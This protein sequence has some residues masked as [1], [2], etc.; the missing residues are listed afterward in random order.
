MIPSST[1]P[2]RTTR[3][4]AD[5]S[6]LAAEAFFSS[7]ARAE[8]VSA[9]NGTPAG[10]G[11]ARRSSARSCAS[12][13]R[14]SS[15]TRARTAWRWSASARAASTSPAPAPRRCSEI[16]RRRADPVRRR[17]HH[18]LPRRPRPRHADAA[19]AG[20]RHRVSP[21]TAGASCWSTTCSSP[22][23]RS[24][25]RMDALIDFGRPAV[26]PARGAGRPRASRAADPRRLR[27]QE[28]ADRARTSR[29]SVRLAEARRRRRGR[30]SRPA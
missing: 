9:T 4:R 30:A 8:R 25:P 14:S 23:A 16:E 1:G 15:A 29:S 26:D 19:R 21:S 17:R 2:T 18:A 22:A 12:R 27:R 10:D 20:H 6:R 11:R 28:P 7:A 3:A 24:A 13:T 5:A